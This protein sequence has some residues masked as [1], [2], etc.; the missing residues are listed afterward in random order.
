MSST[1]RE[2]VI[3][4]AD[5]LIPTV[6]KALC[7]PLPEVRE[8]AAET[9]SNLHSNIGSRA[10][11]DILPH[12]LAGLEHPDRSQFALDGLRQVMAVK[13]KVVLPYLVPQLIAEP[14]NTHALSFL[15]AV[16][17]DSLTRHL[18]KILPALMSAL[19]QKTGSEQEA[20]VCGSYAGL[21]KLV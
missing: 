21:M 2:H 10:L 12:L 14:V 16:A 4:F 6:R 8:A 18:S 17:G 5:S 9:F 3:V 1:S 11:D 13:S 15:S 20:E 7:D 19:S